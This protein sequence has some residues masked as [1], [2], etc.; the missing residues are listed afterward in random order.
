MSF[1]GKKNVYMCQEC[2]RGFVT[3]D[4]DEG[5]TPFM[6][7]CIRDTCSG[8][9][10]SFFY[11]APQEWLEKVNHAVEWYKPTD[12][13]EIATHLQDHVRAGGLLRRIVR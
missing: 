8:T 6:T 1:K 7:T 12:E 2:G 13:A 9:A 3:L 4:V 10:T 5:T 11:K